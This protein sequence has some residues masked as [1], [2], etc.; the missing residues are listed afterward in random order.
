MQWFF[1]PART[2]MLNCQPGVKIIERGLR[3]TLV[4]GL[5]NGKAANSL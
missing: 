5:H 1:L 4:A 2:E 3:T